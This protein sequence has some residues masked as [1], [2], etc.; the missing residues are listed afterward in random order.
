MMNDP[1]LYGDRRVSRRVGE[2][3]RAAVRDRRATYPGAGRAFRKGPCKVC[4]EETDHVGLWE[5][6]PANLCPECAAKI[7]AGA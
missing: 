6:K 4:H 1:I 3:R 7:R 5:G 2:D